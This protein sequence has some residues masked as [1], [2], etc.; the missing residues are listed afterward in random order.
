MPL[1]SFA[2]VQRSVT[3][4][5]DAL[6]CHY[7]KG[8]IVFPWAADID[9]RSCYFQNPPPINVIKLHSFSLRQRISNGLAVNADETQGTL[10]LLP[11]ATKTEPKMPKG[12]SK[13]QIALSKV[14]E[15]PIVTK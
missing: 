1:Q 14:H 12:P 6:V 2:I 13:V 5:V 3:E 4:A 15:M 10:R 9:L 8:H 11:P 7:F